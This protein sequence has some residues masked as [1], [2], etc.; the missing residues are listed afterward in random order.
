V[1][2]TVRNTGRIAV[3]S[4]ATRIDLVSGTGLAFRAGSGCSGITLPPGAQCAIEVRAV[5]A[6]WLVPGVAQTANLVVTSG[7]GASATATLRA[8][9]R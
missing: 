5:P 7:P 8:M 4:V 9:P 3:P 1:T 6:P 2:F